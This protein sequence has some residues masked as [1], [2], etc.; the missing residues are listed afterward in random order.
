[1]EY[2]YEDRRWLACLRKVACGAGQCDGLPNVYHRCQRRLQFEYDVG[3]MHGRVLILALRTH[4]PQQFL[5]RS[6]AIGIG[7]TYAA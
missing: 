7:A 3:R 1:M 6:E 4:Q 5:F 2:G